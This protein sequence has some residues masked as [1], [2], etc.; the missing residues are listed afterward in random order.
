MNKTTTIA[1]L[2]LCLGLR[3]KKEAV[4]NIILDNQID[5]LCLQETEIPVDYPSNLLT[6]KGFDFEN[7]INNVKSRCGIYISNNVSHVRRIELELP[8]K[9]VINIDCWP[10]WG[11]GFLCV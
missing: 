5:I 6:F 7:E 1:S 4:K 8:N 11:H 2:N 3:C 10:A 9:H